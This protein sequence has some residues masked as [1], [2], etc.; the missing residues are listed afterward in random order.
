MN[1]DSYLINQ[2]PEEPVKPDI[3]ARRSSQLA[4]YSL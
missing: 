3:K 2:I 4:M 1:R